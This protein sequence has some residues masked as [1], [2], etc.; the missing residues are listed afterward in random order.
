MQTSSLT[1][2]EKQ[3]LI[4]QMRTLYP[5]LNDARCHTVEYQRLCGQIK[6]L[7]IVYSR[8]FDARASNQTA[9][10]FPSARQFQAEPLG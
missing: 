2:S 6:Q 9:Y 8:L 5:Q 10:G 3:A 1:N 7:A 4:E